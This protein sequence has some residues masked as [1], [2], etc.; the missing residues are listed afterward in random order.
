MQRGLRLI[1]IILV[2][3]TL[4][5]AAF[6][7][8]AQEGGEEAFI[9]GLLPKMSP[10]AKVGQLFVVGFRGSEVTANSDIADLIRNYQVGGVTLSSENGN[11]VNDAN[12]PTQ[13]TTLMSQL[14]NLTRVAR[15]QAG[16]PFI[17]L[18]TALL[19][20][21]DGTPNSEILNGLTPAPSYMALGATWNT[22]DTEMAGKVVGQELSALG[23]NLLLG[24]SLDVHAQPSAAEVDPG[25]N[26]FGGDPYWVGV[27]GQA[28]A[29]GL[30]AGSQ[31][32]LA[33]AAKNFPG[34][35][36]LPDTS[37]TIERSLEDLTNVDLPPFERSMVNPTGKG[38]PLAD[39][40]LTTDM[41]YRGF[42][43]NVRERTAP[44][45]VDSTVLKA[46]LD[47]PAIKTWRD[48][49][50]LFISD[51]PGSPVVRAYY[52]TTNSL[53]VSVTQIALDTFQAGND[54][55]ILDNLSPNAAENATRIRAVIDSFRQKYSTDPTFQTRVDNAV[56]RILRLK[57]RMYPNYDPTAVIVQPNRVA[58]GVNT[59]SSVVQKIANDALTLLWPRADRL[60]LVRP[61]PNDFFLIATDTREYKACPTCSVEATLGVDDL[62]QSIGALY[63]VPS[64]NITTTT[65]SALKAFVTAQPDATDLTPEFQRANWVV[66]AMQT[67]D[68]AYP[69]SDAAQSLL[70]LRPELL[71]NKRVVGF[72]FGPPNGLSADEVER[73]TVLYALYGK[74]R[75]NVDVAVRALSSET[76]PPGRAPIS[77]GALG[78][79]LTTQTAPDPA[80]VIQLA[81]GDEAV[82]GQ[83]TPAPVSLH[84]GDTVR[85]RTGIIADRNGNPVPDGTPVQFIFQYDTD[86]AP[87]I[88]NAATTNGVARTE[89]VLDKT[90]RL[91]IHATSEP[92]L[93][94]VTV[95]ITTGAGVAVVATLEPTPIPTDTP[96]P[97]PTNTP[98]PTPTL[99]LTPLPDFWATLWTQKPQRALWGEWIL[100]LL[101]VMAIGGSGFLAMRARQNDRTRALRVALWCASG[102]LIG[103]IW[104]G[105]GLPGSDFLRDVFGVGAALLA[106]LIGGVVPL[107]YWLRKET[108]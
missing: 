100:G 45:S 27:Q 66:L 9:A 5:N 52:S 59:G 105:A 18:F 13:V 60:T 50:G 44:V 77:I 106:G 46:L 81:V 85:L 22:G 101:G 72:M 103:Y 4:L 79:D 76:A 29:R 87:T 34:Q 51:A 26:V 48:N 14:Q 108:P 89:Y 20:D 1:L 102:G 57:Y 23:V 94:S 49:G 86:S 104:L 82:P 19:Q 31:G 65:F 15:I 95:Q 69:A 67:L 75:P 10:E 92:A 61:G 70:N 16:A 37:F 56:Q 55:L 11:I 43:G 107:W 42:M 98:R 17:P 90:G 88:E 78:Y 7:V 99:T 80:Q 54:L 6:P 21:G 93:N 47:Q 71:D 73:F 40:L 97:P 96:V 3:S 30:Q 41:R 91:L 35:G 58:T 24:P 32:Q 25:V 38:R 68:P 12:A 64:T 39:V 8:W 63:D 36:A 83:P 84:V 2:I 28:Y 62:A 33:V 74:L 53:P